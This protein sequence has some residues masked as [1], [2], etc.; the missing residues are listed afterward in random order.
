[1]NAQP[2]NA[3]RSTVPSGAPFPLAVSVIVTVTR[4]SA[5]ERRETGP[6]PPTSPRVPA[7][8]LVPGDH[9]PFRGLGGQAG[10]LAERPV[11]AGRVLQ[12]VEEPV[13]Q[14]LDR[15]QRI[16]P[17]PRT[18]QRSSVLAGRPRLRTRAVSR[19]E[20]PQRLCDLG[21]DRSPGDDHADHRH[22]RVSVSA[23]TDA[24]DLSP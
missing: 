1:L 24:A 15:L 6:G 14:R 11:A 17:V 4:A 22:R 8:M 2:N 9:L 7:G 21:T 12:P 23:G 5:T 16:I 10:A 20:I 18:W 19:E 3:C 13:G